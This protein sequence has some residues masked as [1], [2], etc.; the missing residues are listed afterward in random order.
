MRLRGTGSGF[1]YNIGRVVTAGFPFVIGIIL[2][3][4]ANPIAIIRWVAVVPAIGVV[5]VLSG[6]AQETKGNLEAEVD[7]EQGGARSLP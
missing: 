5:F 3:S 6:L 7:A 1:C 4:G 2:R